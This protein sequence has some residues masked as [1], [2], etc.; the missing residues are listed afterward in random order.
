[1]RDGLT[2][3][4]LEVLFNQKVRLAGG[5][6]Y[7]LAPTTAGIPDRLAIFPGGRMYLVE[8]KTD[9]GRLSPIQAFLHERLDLEFGVIVITLY[10]RWMIDRFIRN[11]LDSRDPRATPVPGADALD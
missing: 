1:V 3:A 4:Q 11:V 9:I 2:E 10:G 6:S 7:K 8:L 5:I